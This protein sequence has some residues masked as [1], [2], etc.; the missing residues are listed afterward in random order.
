MSVFLAVK[1]D[2]AIGDRDFDTVTQ[3]AF[4]MEG[5]ARMRQLPTLQW[6]IWGVDPERRQAS[7]FYLFKNREAAEG[8]A[9]QCVRVL[10]ERPGISNVTT[11]IWTICEE[12]TRGTMGPIDLPMISEL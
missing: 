2:V 12:Q 8:Y 7:G 5:V 3:E 4:S 1:M 11:Q 9:H 6:K 10:Q